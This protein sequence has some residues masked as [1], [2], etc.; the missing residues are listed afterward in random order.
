MYWRRL[1][2]G[3]EAGKTVMK[4]TTFGA[5]CAFAGMAVLGAGASFAQIT[6]PS[7]GA[8]AELGISV[9]GGGWAQ[10]ANREEIVLFLLDVA[11]TIAL[12]AAFVYHP[13]R[14][15]LP[16]TLASLRLPTLFYLYALIGMVVGFL[17]VQHGYIIGFV[18]FGIGALLRFRSNLDDPGDTVEMILVTVLGLCVGLNLP[19]MAIMIG[20]VAW[21]VT[22]V[23]GR[24][25]AVALS[26]KAEDQAAL[27]AALAHIEALAAQKH[28][29]ITNLRRSHG[30]A[31]AELILITIGKHAEDD[32]DSVLAGPL[33]AVGVI[34]KV[35]S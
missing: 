6:G 29:R 34:W 30:K 4:L 35:T 5:G 16:V 2:T 18:V 14:R 19:V 33:D 12:T 25:G 22:L 1:D 27:N 23:A 32:V 17:V 8:G 10:W 15:R 3:M 20:A 7:L 21:I 31:A 28:W 26:L 9:S 24:R 11:T 13:I